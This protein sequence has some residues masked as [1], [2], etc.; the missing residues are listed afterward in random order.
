MSKKT[1]QQEQYEYYKRQND[2][3]KWT[4]ILLFGVPLGLVVILGFVFLIG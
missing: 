2:V 3:D 1:P 4:A